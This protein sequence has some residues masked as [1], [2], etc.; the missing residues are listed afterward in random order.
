MHRFS[1]HD[2]PALQAKNEDAVIAHLTTLSLQSQSTWVAYV[3]IQADTCE[4]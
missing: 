4:Q 2:K 3:D 1:L